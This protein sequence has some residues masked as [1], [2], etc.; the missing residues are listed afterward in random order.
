MAN[1]AETFMRAGKKEIPVYLFTGFLDSGKT[2]FI[3]ETL[4]DPAFNSG[5]KT[6]MLLCEEGEVELNPMKFSGGN[7]E[8]VVLDDEEEL[9]QGFLAGLEAIH[10]IDR[11]VV[12]YNGM[13][14][15]DSFY[16]AMPPNWVVYQEMCLVDA[17]T[18][19]TYNAN[20]RN[21]VYDKLKSVGT[22]VFKKF[23]R[24]MDKMDYHKI[25][26]AASRQAE[27]IYEYG[28]KDIEFDNIEDPMPFNVEDPVIEIGDRDYALWYRDI[29]EEE[30]KYYTQPAKIITVKGRSL[31][32]G[33]LKDD[34]FVIGRHIMTCCVDDIQ[35]GG[36]VAKYDGAQS[37][38]HGGWVVVTAAI[39]H[40]YNEMYGEKGPVL[41]VTEVE[42]VEPLE[43]EVA[44]FM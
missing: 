27:I 13:W 15:L 11:V 12:E 31:L 7:V 24:D 37:L 2:T 36:L 9:D 33:G 18:F 35:F 21:L 43:D 42:K 19:L 1:N 5:E 44:T 34:E 38:D 41:H 39:Y 17:T 14:T 40:E 26:R 8:I 22:V 23:T 28:E 30:E 25:V 29:T 20:M 4:E 32:G 3:Q 16:G 6:L 10:D